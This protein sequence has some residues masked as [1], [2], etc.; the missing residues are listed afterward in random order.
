M[1]ELPFGVSPKKMFLTL[2]GVEQRVSILESK[3]ASLE[4]ARPGRKKV[5]IIAKKKGVCGINPD[6]DSSTC[7]DAGVYR[8]QQG[9]RGT[10]CTEI[11]EAYYREYRAK[12][13][14]TVK[15][16]ETDD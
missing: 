6:R 4:R 13:K 5:P 16:V 1:T 10:A 8:F 12:N 9:C 3:V 2:D 14:P 7:E 15:E 11:N